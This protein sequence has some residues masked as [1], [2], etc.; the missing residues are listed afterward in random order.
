MLTVR[1]NDVNDEAP[2]FTSRFGYNVV[3]PENLPVNSIV[4]DEVSLEQ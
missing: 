2:V 3:V 4:S 1:L